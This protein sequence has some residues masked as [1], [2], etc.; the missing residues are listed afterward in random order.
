MWIQFYIQP[1][2][3]THGSDPDLQAS[4]SPILLPRN[5]QELRL[6]L[7]SDLAK[8]HNITRVIELFDFQGKRSEMYAVKQ[9]SSWP[10]RACDQP[11]T[12]EFPALA[13]KHIDDPRIIPHEREGLKRVRAVQLTCI[14]FSY[15][16]FQ[17]RQLLDHGKGDDGSDW[18]IVRDMR[19]LPGSRRRYRID[20]IVFQEFRRILTRSLCERCFHNAYDVVYG[21]MKKY[22]R[23]DGILYADPNIGNV[24][25]SMDLSDA[26]FVDWGSW[27]VEKVCA[28]FLFFFLSR[29]NDHRSPRNGIRNTTGIQLNL[30]FTCT[31]SLFN[32]YLSTVV[33]LILS[34][35]CTWHDG[36]VPYLG[37]GT[38]AEK[39][40]LSGC[41]IFPFCPC[42]L[43]YCDVKIE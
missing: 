14:T 36:G 21:R 5:G 18:T 28:T 16:F 39:R 15:T 19:V 4:V 27:K 33:G 24:L 37:G 7:L 30:L 42:T 12:Q 20:E 40:N 9:P 31:N 2:N 32:G 11:S 34:K 3:Q 26:V 17:V 23:E 38:G 1:T 29:E 35:T 10:C 22:V 6:T 43:L 13:K 8:D 25:F 41:L